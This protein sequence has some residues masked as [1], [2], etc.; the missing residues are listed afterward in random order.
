MDSQAGRFGGSE[1]NQSK[2]KAKKAAVS[3]CRSDGG[4]KCKVIDLYYNQCGALVSGASYAVSC[5]AP[6]IESAIKSATDDCTLKT[7]ECKPFHARCSY[8]TRIR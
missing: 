4:K 5:S 2:S 6:E 7:S 3:E 8:P 1:N